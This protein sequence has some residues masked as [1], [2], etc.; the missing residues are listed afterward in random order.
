MTASLTDLLTEKD[1]ATLAELLNGLITFDPE[2]EISKL[3]TPAQIGNLVRAFG[4]IRSSGQGNYGHGA[5]EIVVRDGKVAGVNYT[6]KS[7]I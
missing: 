1:Q 5:I 2:T 4:L 6:V 7:K 3:F